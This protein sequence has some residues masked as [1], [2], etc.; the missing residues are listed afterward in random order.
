MKFLNKFFGSNPST[1]NTNVQLV[2]ESTQQESHSNKLQQLF[3]DNEPPSISPSMTN[4]RNK[5]QEFL[6]ADYSTRGFADG[7]E[8]HNTELLDQKVLIFKSE[9]RQIVDEE[10]DLRK[11]E[12]YKL[13]NQLIETHGLSER[14]M[15]QLKLRI[16]EYKDVISKFE[17]EKQLSAEDE[18]LI[19]NSIHKYR[20]GYIR[21][22]KDWHE[23]KLFAQSTGLF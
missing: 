2:E 7:Y 21:G 13:R 4:K 17:L 19:M 20:E 5:L 10:I 14:L 1:T 22:C 9:F 3:M 16:D 18:G 15:E 8:H 23:V 12:V 11:Q 6:D